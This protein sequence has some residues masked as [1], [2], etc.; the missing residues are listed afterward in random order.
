MR[1]IVVTGATSFIAVSLLK[2]LLDNGDYIYAVVRPKSN[3]LYR[4]PQ[5][6]NLKIIELDLK[7]ISELPNCI[8]DEIN[9][10]YHLAWEGIRGEQRDDINLQKSN[11]I[12]SKEAI[13]AAKKLKVSIFIGSGS[14]AEYGNIDGPISE[15]I[16]ENPNSQYGKFK[17]AARLY[18]ELYA[19]QENIRF[20][21][22]RI[23]SS[24]GEYDFENTLIMDCIRKM[25]AGKEIYLT[26]CKQKWDFIYVGDI[27]KALIMLS[28]NE[29]CSGVYN[30]ASGQTRM[31][32]EYV[33]EIKEI[34]HS[35][36]E[37]KFGAV[38]Y[39]PNGMVNLEPVICKIKDELSWNPETTFE[40]GI[41]NILEWMG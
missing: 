34:L 26:E 18:L 16:E 33:L 40:N 32:K 14:Q 12:A 29:Y 4:L 37:I 5:N 19:K 23:F 1:K 8:H 35:S 10:F 31:L 25:K 13:S 27:A 2:K 3:N 11:F 6:K 21:W 9:V 17:L 20:I 7:D 39:G 30:I 41:K 36:S 15:E 24:Y 22:V 38:A 28:E